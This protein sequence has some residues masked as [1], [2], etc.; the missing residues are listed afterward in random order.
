VAEAPLFHIGQK[1]MP[2]QPLDI[3]RAP[4]QAE[5]VDDNGHMNVAYYVLMFDRATD[6]LLDR[7]GLGAAYRQRTNHSIYVLEAHVTYE[8]EVKEGDMLRVAT[9][10][11]DADAKRLH[12][13][14]TMYHA[15]AGYRAATTELLALHVDLAGPTG[16]KFAATEQAAVDAM[17]DEH[18]T[19]PRPPQLGRVIGIR[20]AAPR[21]ESPLPAGPS[22]SLGVR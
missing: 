11:V 10:L 1:T 16:L 7:L 5:W 22:T 17:L 15:A 3:Y 13:F 14:H 6:A 8:R 20:P 18:R 2:T 19:L 9:Q 21:P 4:V 12:F